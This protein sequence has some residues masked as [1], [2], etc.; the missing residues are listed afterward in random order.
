MTPRCSKRTVAITSI[1]T[2][3]NLP[4]LK[5][6]ADNARALEKYDPALIG[7]R[8]DDDNPRMQLEPRGERG[9]IE[10]RAVRP[11]DKKNEK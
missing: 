9:Y 5:N 8:W 1:T 6:Q 2:R 7:Y 3:N 11:L 4:P 10:L